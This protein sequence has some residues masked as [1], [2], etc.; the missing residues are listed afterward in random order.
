M[1]VSE[2]FEPFPSPTSNVEDWLAGSSRVGKLDSVESR[3]VATDILASSAKHILE[4]DIERVDA[5]VD[6]MGA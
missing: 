6:Q 2:E 1:M 3:G 5:L 4:S